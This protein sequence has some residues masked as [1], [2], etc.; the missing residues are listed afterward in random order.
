[1][2]GLRIG[3]CVWASYADGRLVVALSRNVDCGNRPSASASA[4]ASASSSG[5]VTAGAALG[6][7]LRLD[8]GLNE[9]GKPLGEMKAR[10]PRMIEVGCKSGCSTRAR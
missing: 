9:R 5:Y 10:Y 8:R 1:M 3:H 6:V 4:I 7:A 2:C